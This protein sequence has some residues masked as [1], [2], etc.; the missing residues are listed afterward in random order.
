M[1]AA[2]PRCFL[3]VEP[4]QDDVAVFDNVV[5]AFHADKALFPG[6]GKGTQFQE[7]LVVDDFRLDKS[8]LKVAV[9]LAGCLRCLC[10][11]LDGPCTCLILAGGQKAHKAQRFVACFDQLVQTCFGDTQVLQEH[12]LLVIIEFRDLGLDAGAS[13]SAPS[14]ARSSSATFAA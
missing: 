11:D 6:G 10:A 13:L 8:P 1:P 2:F 14:F 12:S 7:G 3:H 4:E 5:F 9:D